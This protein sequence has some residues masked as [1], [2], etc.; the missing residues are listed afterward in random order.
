MRI[1]KFLKV[2]RIIKRRTVAKEACD[3]G[4]VAVN[5][6]PAK[7]GTNLEVRDTVKIEFGNKWLTL[8]V[9]A[10]ENSTKK[11]DASKMYTILDE[12]WK[13]KASEPEFF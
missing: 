12:E 11:E 8:R 9:D 3:Q 4:R 2:A 7:S 5:G 13:E 6:R 1:D 10:L